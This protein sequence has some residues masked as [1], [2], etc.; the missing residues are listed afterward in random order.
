VTLVRRDV[1]DAF[2]A[3]A[4]EYDGEHEGL[5]ARAYWLHSRIDAVLRLLG[6]GPGDVLDAGM[7]PGRLCAELDRRGW[8][9]W[10]VDGSER[11]V[12]LAQARLPH[13]REHLLAGQVERLP[14]DASTFDA[15]VATGV[16]GYVGDPRAV[17]RELARVVRPGGCV[18]VGAGNAR[19]PHRVWRRFVGPASGR[20]NPAF[21]KSRPT[22][23]GR[24]KATLAAAD[25]EVEAVER[26]GFVVIPWP[27]DRRIPELAAWLARVSGSR[28]SPVR[29]LAATQIVVVARK[30]RQAAA[31]PD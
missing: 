26:A 13:L 7:G 24:L 27:L 5:S 22:T 8:T 12:E 14:F 17:V 1:I 15:A 16:L 3:V 19:T 11:M 18:L 25:L 6:D 10:G 2:D 28:R 31:R 4:A 9:V 20:R 23:L 30:P 21:P 29:R